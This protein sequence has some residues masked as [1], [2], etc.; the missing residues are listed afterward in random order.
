MLAVISVMFALASCAT[1]RPSDWIR[2]GSTTRD[3]V[4]AQ[5]G[6][7]DLIRVMPEGEVAVYR[8][9]APTAARP[10]LSIPLVEAAGDQG[11]IRTREQPLERGL[12]VRGVGTGARARPEKEFRIRFDRNG[13][14]QAL[15]E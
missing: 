7:P 11:T 1:V 12:G 14:V 5:Y 3:E 15:E 13:V 8:P 9:T 2:V 4:V 6:E 10:R